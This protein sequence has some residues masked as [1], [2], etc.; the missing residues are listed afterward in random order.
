MLKTLNSN[1]LDWEHTLNAGLCHLKKDSSAVAIGTIKFP[2]SAPDLHFHNLTTGFVKLLYLILQWWNMSVLS[3]PFFWP[4]KNPKN[5]KK[6]NF[7]KDQTERN[8]FKSSVLLK[9]LKQ[10]MT[11]KTWLWNRMSGS[12]SNK[13]FKVLIQI[14]SVVRNVW[15]LPIPP[16]LPW[17]RFQQALHLFKRQIEGNLTQ[18]SVV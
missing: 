1:F 3:K 12:L 4:E 10:A 16:A 2:V 17:R 14:I 9:C 7:S 13:Y 8:L 18:S 5:T 11:N 6:Q 15:L